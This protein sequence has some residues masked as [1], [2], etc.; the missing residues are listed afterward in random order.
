M[1]RLRGPALAARDSAMLE[2][3]ERGWTLERIAARY[4]VHHTTAMLACRREA[5]RRMAW[6]VRAR[7]EKCE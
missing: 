5:F 3:R 1:T 7:C 2:L 4:G 6:L